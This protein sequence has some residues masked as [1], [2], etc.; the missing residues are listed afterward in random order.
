MEKHLN[1]DVVQ[2]HYQHFF[3]EPVFAQEVYSKIRLNAVTSLVPNWCTY[4]F[5]T[6]KYIN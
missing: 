5:W 2:T 3:F 4:K 6:Y 1:N